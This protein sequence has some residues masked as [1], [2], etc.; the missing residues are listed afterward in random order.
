MAVLRQ[1]PL[2]SFNERELDAYLRH[3]SASEPDA[4][5]RLAHLA[6]KS[7]GQ[8][9]RLGPLGEW[10]YELRDGDPL[11]CLSASDCVTLV[12]Q[13]YAMALA[14]DWP[15]FVRTLLRIRYR[16]GVV[17]FLT[18]NHFTEADWNVNN[19]WLF[20]DLSATLGGAESGTMRVRIDRERFFAGFGYGED[21]GVQTIE[22]PYLVR[23]AITRVEPA[24]R[25]GD[26]IEIVRGGDD[27]MHVSH[28][29]LLFRDARGRLTILH[30]TKPAV[31]EQPLAEYLEAHPEIAGIKV[32][33]MRG[34][35]R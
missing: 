34:E 25:D 3:L 16:D 9:Y 33:R 12:E 17:G 20:E 24:L 15:D 35:G 7:I 4:L 29:G 21:L 32:L 18:R 2:A 10:P 30:A 6:R 13:T 26:V 5:K 14:A 22:T 8:P 1:A 28:M 31:R 23:E 11:Y 27:A 19:G